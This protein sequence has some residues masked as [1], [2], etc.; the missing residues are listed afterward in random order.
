MR[1]EAALATWAPQLSVAVIKGRRNAD[2]DDES[3]GGLSETKDA[4]EE[5]SA[6]QNIFRWGDGG[7]HGK[8][9][10]GSAAAA[11]PQSD[12]TRADVVLGCLGHRLTDARRDELC[13]R[14]FGMVIWDARRIGFGS[15]AA[16][17]KATAKAQ[18]KAGAS[19]SSS[20]SSSSSD[21]DADDEMVPSDVDDC[22]WWQLTACSPALT[23]SPR[24]IMLTDKTLPRSSLALAWR[25][26][27]LMPTVFRS[28]LHARR[29]ASGEG[30]SK[31][32]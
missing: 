23:S 25:T 17:A 4:K 19:S 10:G 9:A 8:G 27:W 1:W 5:T 3:D 26:A 30:F 6:H 12:C 29:W 7:V 22:D 28:P 2:V 15:E 16:K 13:A 24:R 18:A 20:S 32:R 21:G 31:V 11:S 14:K